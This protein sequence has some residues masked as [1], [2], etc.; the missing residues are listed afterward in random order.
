MGARDC[1]IESR[2]IFGVSSPATAFTGQRG[3]PRYSI[4]RDQLDFLIGRCF[5]VVD[6]DIATLLGVSVRTVERRLFEF[7]LSVR[8]TYS[9]ID[10]EELDQLNSRNAGRFKST[11]QRLASRGSPPRFKS[12]TADW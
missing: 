4:P 10:N 3:R 12:P 5:S 8:L 7:G 6:R 9:N 1:L 11:N 2:D